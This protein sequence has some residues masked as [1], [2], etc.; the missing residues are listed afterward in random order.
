MGYGGWMMGVEK[1]VGGE[2]LNLVGVVRG[3]V[4]GVVEV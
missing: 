1:F 4:V 3:W 2:G